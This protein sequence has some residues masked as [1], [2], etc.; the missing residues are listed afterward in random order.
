MWRSKSNFGVSSLLPLWAPGTEFRSAGLQ[1]NA[2][3]NDHLTGPWLYQPSWLKLVFPRYFHDSGCPFH[4]E[5]PVLRGASASAGGWLTS[6]WAA[7]QGHDLKDELRSCCV[8][9]NFRRCK[10]SR[11][12]NTSGAT[13]ASQ[14]DVNTKSWRNQLKKKESFFCHF[15]LLLISTFDS[16]NAAKRRLAA[17]FKAK[18]KYFSGKVISWRGGVGGVIIQNTV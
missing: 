17:T 1:N 15:L 10:D 13:A 12:S 3:L 4:K 9:Y 16:R 14:L 18:A 6:A 8:M 2:L 11:N 5:T 7:G